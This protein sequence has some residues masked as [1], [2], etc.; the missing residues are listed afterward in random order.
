MLQHFDVEHADVL[1]SISVLPFADTA[2][3]L[4]LGLIMLDWNTTY[5][6]RVK[7]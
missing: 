7:L 4:R 3:I 6:I 5:D 1:I 2:V